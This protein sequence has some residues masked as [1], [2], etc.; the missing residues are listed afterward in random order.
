VSRESLGVVEPAIDRMESVSLESVLDLAALQ[1]RIDRKYLVAP[2]V[3]TAL[4][5]DA[6]CRLAVLEI[7]EVR[8]FQY[9]S[10]Y[11]DT[12]ALDSYHA[13]AHGRRRRFK[14]RTRTYLDS[15]ITVLEVKVRGGRGETVKHRMPYDT[16]DRLCLTT[17]GMAFV[18]EH[19]DAAAV[20]LLAPV[21]TTSYRRTTFVDMAAGMRLT[22][23]ADVVCSSVHGPSVAVPDHLLLETKSLGP[24]TAADRFLWRTGHRPLTVSKY[25]LGMAA[26]DP[27]LPANKWNRTLRRYFGWAPD[28]RRA[29]QT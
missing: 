8:A 3:L 27:G 7:D 29:T 18:A 21:L 19:I 1:T 16:A 26:L 4:A 14:V 24:T 13:A 23:D 11:F 9:E 25:C 5:E 22:C 10:V 2:E 12:P 6:G 20:P 15:G 28:R 17:E